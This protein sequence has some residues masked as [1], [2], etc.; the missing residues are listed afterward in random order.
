MLMDHPSLKSLFPSLWNVETLRAL[1][2][3]IKTWNQEVFGMLGKEA[4]DYEE[5]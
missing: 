5:N 2:D 4:G 3:T 1:K